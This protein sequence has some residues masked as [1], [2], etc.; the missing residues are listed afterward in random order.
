MFIWDTVKRMKRLMGADPS[1]TDN[2]DKED[3]DSVLEVD[4]D[5]GAGE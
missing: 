3:F 4:D 1:A 2:S 5:V